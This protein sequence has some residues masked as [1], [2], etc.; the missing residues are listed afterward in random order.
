MAV[1]NRLFGDA[2]LP[3]G[4]TAPPLRRTLMAVL[5]PE[6]EQNLRDDNPWWRG[7]PTPPLP[8][9]LMLR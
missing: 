6:L 9:M 2:G 4:L 3:P 7:E 1:K 8:P 5:N